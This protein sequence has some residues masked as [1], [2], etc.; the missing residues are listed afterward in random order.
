M[1]KKVFISYSHKDENIANRLEKALRELRISFWIDKRELKVGDRIFRNVLKGILET[2]YLIVLI[3]KNSLRSK[4]VKKELIKALQ[5]EKET[6]QSKII[7]LR[8][9]KCAAP[10]IIRDRLYA[11][12]SSERDFYFGLSELLRKIDPK[13]VKNISYEA[14]K[15]GSM[16]NLIL[17]AEW[18]KKHRLTENEKKSLVGMCLAA[19]DSIRSIL[20]TYSF[21]EN[22][23]YTYRVP[24]DLRVL[25]FI[26]CEEIEVIILQV[27]VEKNYYTIDCF[28][29]FS[30][31]RVRL[32]KSPL[33][34]VARSWREKKPILKSH[35]FEY[36]E[37]I[38]K[39][40]EDSLNCGI[41]REFVIQEQ[42]HPASAVAF[43]FQECKFSESNLCLPIIICIDSDRKEVFPQELIKPMYKSLEI[44]VQEYSNRTRKFETPNEGIQRARESG[45]IDELLKY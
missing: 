35:S 12:I 13:S 1:R 17:F 40:I 11:D 28:D 24:P 15:V 33:T 14:E 8:L 22:R 3:S 9:D 7:P 16:N 25:I 18:F 41:P 10:T 38:E 30:Y 43:P 2:R 31:S 27:M 23:N 39:Y 42:F 19:R 36:T 34:I 20:V 6:K 32:E 5:L 21:I 26:V 4:W 37:N 44:I 45:V 29:R